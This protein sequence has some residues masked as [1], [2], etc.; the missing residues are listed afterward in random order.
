MGLDLRFCDAC[1]R[2]PDEV[3][4]SM[5]A[6]IWAGPVA[7]VGDAAKLAAIDYV[8]AEATNTNASFEYIKALSAGR[9]IFLIHCI[10]LPQGSKLL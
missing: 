8:L 6:G 4:P 1:P 7:L 10:I 3:L 2:S 5:V 9:R